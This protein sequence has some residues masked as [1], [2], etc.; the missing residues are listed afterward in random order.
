MERLSPDDARILQL[1]SDVIAGHTL[2]VVIVDPPEGGDPPGLELVRRRVQSRLAGLPRA[3]QRLAPTP[4]GLA[5]PAWID[6]ADFD[7]RRHV[8]LA[9]E[10]VRDVDDLVAYAGKVMAERLDHSRPLWCIDAAGPLEDWRTGLVI[11]I[12]QCMADGV[13]AL[14]FLSR[15]LWDDDREGPDPGAP[16]QWDPSP[17][18]GAT[19]LLAADGDWTASGRTISTMRCAGCCVAIDTAITRILPGRQTNSPP[20]FS[21]DGYSP[22]NDRRGVTPREAP[23]RPPSQWSCSSCVFRI[24]IRSGIV[25]AE[26][27]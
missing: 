26:I 6:D 13:T 22:V 21:A 23:I 8:R 15:L 7:I 14:R 27:G 20:R 2:K 24:T 12:H 18:P 1:E 11:R 3:R 5:T 10:P 17:E 19:R 4:L 16:S 9:S 25:R